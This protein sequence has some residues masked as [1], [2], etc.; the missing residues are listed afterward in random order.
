MQH[1]HRSRVLAVRVP[2]I[3]T[4]ERSTDTARPHLRMTRGLRTLDERDHLRCQPPGS[5]RLHHVA[6]NAQLD[7]GV[8]SSEGMPV[9]AACI[10]RLLQP[11]IARKESLMPGEDRLHA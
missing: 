1:P 7:R 10:N 4:K 3:V 5:D 6:T 11:P 2:T 9:A 8:L